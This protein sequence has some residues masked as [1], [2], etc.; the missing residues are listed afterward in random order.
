MS[1]CPY[2]VQAINGIFGMAQNFGDD[3]EVAVDYI[4]TFSSQGELGSMHGPNEVTADIAQLCVHRVAPSRL[5]EVMHCQNKSY[6][7]A[8]TNW[9][10][11]LQELRIP[12]GHVRQCID[13]GEGARMLAASF[14]RTKLRGDT[15]SPTIR[16]AGKPYSGSR[17]ANDFARAACAE[18]DPPHP[19]CNAIPVPPPVNVV[20]LSDRRCADCQP[21]RYER[22]LKSRIGNPVIRVLD[23]SDSEGK[24]LYTATKPGNLP[25]LI[26][27]STLEAD[28]DAFESFQRG[29]K[30]VGGYSVAPLG[31]EYNPTCV[32]AQDCAR[33]ECK[34]VFSCRK[35]VP[36]RLD[37]YI[38]SKCPFA[39][40]AINAMEEVFRDFGSLDFRTHYIGNIDATRG[41]SSMHGPSEVEEDRRE[42]CAI[43]HYPVQRR[44]LKYFWCRNQNILDIAWETCTGGTTGIDAGV[45][46]TCSEGA[47]GERLLEASF[48]SSLAVGIGASPTWIVNNKFK[49]S[50]IDSTT[51][52]KFICEHNPKL[53]PCAAIAAAPAP[54]PVTSQPNAGCQ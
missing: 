32:S 51:I 13:S 18:L 26:F 15:G 11:C 48:K 47:E 24:R 17:K 12:V 14:E 43:A 1:Q 34:D 5:L 28:Q 23:Y 21:E 38:M 46:R 10:P 4:G 6:K 8:A 52:K 41:L 25:V 45:I 44:Y 36:S 50:G 19:Y 9:E 31:G 16:I 33:A 42:L 22:M 35:E 20:V 39:V 40:K 53:K 54:A 2:G 3:L 49:H 7:D 29:L 27:D 37:V 30:N